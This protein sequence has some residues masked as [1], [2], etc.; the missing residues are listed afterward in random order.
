MGSQKYLI[1]LSYIINRPYAAGPLKVTR[2]VETPKLQFFMFQIEFLRMHVC[3][4]SIQD[5]KSDQF[6]ILE[7]FPDI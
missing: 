7:I 3:E 4:A 2:P 6:R 5:Y 1:P